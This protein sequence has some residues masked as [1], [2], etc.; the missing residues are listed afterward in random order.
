MWIL[1]ANHTTHPP[2]PSPRLEGGTGGAATGRHRGFNARGAELPSSLHLIPATPGCFPL[3]LDHALLD[4]DSQ[5][6][7]Q[8]THPAARTR[9]DP[10]RD[11]ATRAKP[12][13]GRLTATVAARNVLV[14][15]EVTCL[16]PWLQSA[17]T[18]RGGAVKGR[19][20]RVSPRTVT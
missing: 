17:W 20:P 2:Q 5:L 6:Q 3:S 9:S 18:S 19:E 16:P 11:D 7:D 10:P 15:W 8:L 1:G 4:P 12:D 14:P 13:Q